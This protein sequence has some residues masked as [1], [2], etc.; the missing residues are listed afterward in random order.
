MTLF[1]NEAKLMMHLG[2]THRE[3]IQTKIEINKSRKY[4]QEIWFSPSEF[5]VNKYLPVGVAAPAVSF[6]KS[7]TKKITPSTVS[8]II[9]IK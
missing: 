4:R 5:Q 8:N 6:T 3:V 7:P 2:A 9:E 1:D